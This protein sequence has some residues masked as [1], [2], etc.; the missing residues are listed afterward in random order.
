M[1]MPFVKLDDGPVRVLM[2]MLLPQYPYREGEWSRVDAAYQA[3]RSQV[4]AALADR[5]VSDDG[6]KGVKERAVAAADKGLAPFEAAITQREGDLGRLKA[7]AVIPPERNEAAMADEEYARAE[8][9]KVG[10]V[11]AGV[12][13]EEACRTENWTVINACRRAAAAGFPVISAES[14]RRGEALLIAHGRFAQQIKSLSDVLDA[15]RKI[16]GAAKGGVR[17]LAQ[18]HGVQL[19]RV[20]PS[21]GAA[22]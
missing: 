13:Y 7:K 3:A 19:R 17:G 21:G 8:L 10:K 11:L 1:P 16:L 15:D 5:E 6:V 20:P 18:P 22:A 2:T 4:R 14:Q 12:K 9:S